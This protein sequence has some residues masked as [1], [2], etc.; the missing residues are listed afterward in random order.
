[1]APTLLSASIPSLPG[2]PARLLRTQA[3]SF[4]S[5]WCRLWAHDITACSGKGQCDVVVF[6][7]CGWFLVFPLLQPNVPAPGT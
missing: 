1:M 6:Y 3:A 4:C 2:A 5:P 7:T